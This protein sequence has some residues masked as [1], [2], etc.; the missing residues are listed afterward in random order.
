M[1][2]LFVLVLAIQA[3]GILFGQ[4]PDK[5]SFQAVIRDAN[6]LLISNAT[7][8]IQIS[9]LQDSSNG[10]V[11]FVESHSSMT[12]QNGLVTLRIGDGLNQSGTLSNI[13][14]SDGPYFLKTE[15]DTSGGT[16]Y[17]I[18]G[19]TQLL[20][21]PYALFADSAGGIVG[22]LNELDPIFSSSVAIGISSID[23]NNWNNKID[24]EADGDITNELQTISRNGLTVTLSNGGGSFMD[25]IRAYQPGSGI[26]IMNDTIS[27]A[28]QGIFPPGMIIPFAG[29]ANNTPS[30]WLLCDGAA[31]SRISYSNLFSVS[32]I[33]W[34][35]GD[36]VTTFNLPDLRG[37]FLRGQ[38]LGSGN[39]PDAN[40]RYAINGGN[41]GNNVGSYQSDQLVSHTHVY[42]QPLPITDTDRGGASSIWSL[43]NQA[44]SNTAATGG[45]E[46]RPKN[47]SINYLIKY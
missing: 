26:Q 24:I 38:D 15:I 7:V 13:D 19:T 12:N 30:G 21:V 44:A 9:V 46:T 2:R 27:V 17:L 1:R 4:A 33:S 37:R 47:A 35:T 14:W 28:S 8:G 36:G 23:T 11:V 40:G 3:W 43:D 25:S 41:T 31:I 5:I 6:D 22:P 45:S 29:S 42:S 20:S 39:D 16:N 32:G 10:T 18:S 34:G